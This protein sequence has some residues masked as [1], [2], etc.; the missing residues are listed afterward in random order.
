MRVY[1]VL[2]AAFAL[3]LAA[4]VSTTAGPFVPPAVAP[5]FAESTPPLLPQPA[6]VQPVVSGTTLLIAWESASPASSFEVVVAHPEGGTPVA[7]AIVHGARHASIDIG[8][9]DFTA[10]SYCVRVRS[11]PQAGQEDQASAFSRCAPISAFTCN[12]EWQ[13]QAVPG[14]IVV[15]VFGSAR[16]DLAA[17]DLASVRLGDGRGRGTTP[18]STGFAHVEDAGG[19]DG[20]RDLVA[21]F[22]MGE[23]RRNGDLDRDTASFYL[24]AM[25]RGGSPACGSIDLRK[26]R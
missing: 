24:Q 16:M 15:V 7:P 4:G 25:T 19:I 5:L 11:I 26:S 22:D 12:M 3:C 20:Y 6:D 17:L 14:A 1:R 9:V 18:A 23:M 10:G 8:D 21:R 13:V 2:G